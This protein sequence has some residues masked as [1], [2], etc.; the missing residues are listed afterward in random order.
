MYLI[1]LRSKGAKRERERKR[2]REKERV[3]QIGI[4]ERYFVKI[5]IVYDDMTDHVTHNI[6]ITHVIII[7]NCYHHY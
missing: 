1:F 5:I 4:F 7:E 6:V 2:E 3:K